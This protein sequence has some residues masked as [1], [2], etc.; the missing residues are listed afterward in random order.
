[1]KMC[2]TLEEINSMPFRNKIIIRLKTSFV[3]FKVSYLDNDCSKL[4]H[5][6]FLE[7]L[8]ISE[9]VYP[10]NIMTKQFQWMIKNRE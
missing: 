8:L 1:M 3:L 5:L 10:M 6:Y 2:I 7:Y 9:S 4:N